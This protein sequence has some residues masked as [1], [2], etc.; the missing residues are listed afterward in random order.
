MIHSFLPICLGKLKVRTARRSGLFF[1][2][3]QRWADLACGGISRAS[4][5]YAGC[6]HVA[7][8]QQID[9]NREILRNKPTYANF[10]L[11]WQPE[12][13][14][15]TLRLVYQSYDTGNSIQGVDSPLD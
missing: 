8:Q 14:E 5:Q 6:P 1:A 10:A 11:V 2:L 12:L 7:I 9:R 13:L 3:P 4:P 15:K